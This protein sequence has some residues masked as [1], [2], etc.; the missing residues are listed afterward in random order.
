MIET[1]GTEIA[2]VIAVI[3]STLLITKTRKVTDPTFVKFRYLLMGLVLT[4]IVLYF[5]LR[6]TGVNP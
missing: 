1:N 6:M 5:G 4:S 3:T 2:L